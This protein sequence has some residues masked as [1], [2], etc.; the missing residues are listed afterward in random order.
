MKTIIPA[1]AI[2]I[3]CIALASTYQ[4]KT[5]VGRWETKLPDNTIAGI[6]YKADHTYQGYVN[7][8]VFVAGSYDLKKDTLSMSDNGCPIKGLY[9]ITFF[10][11]SVRYNVIAD[12]CKGRK[13]DVDKAVLG[14]VKSTQ[15][16]GK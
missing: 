16:V 3:S 11:D 7:K 1:L 12:S 2:L 14:R 5:L 10:A 4:E 8:K 13:H 15:N 6:I 9:K